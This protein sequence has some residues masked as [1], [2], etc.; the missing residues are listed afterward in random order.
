MMTAVVSGSSIDV[1][2]VA[3]PVSS[4]VAV[5]STDGGNVL[6]FQD[7]NTAISDGSIYDIADMCPWVRCAV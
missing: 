4:L 1:G 7:G 6:V 5:V 2:G 3:V